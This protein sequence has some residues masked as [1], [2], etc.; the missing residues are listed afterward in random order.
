MSPL[1]LLACVLLPAWPSTAVRVVHVNTL[2]TTGVPVVLVGAQESKRVLGLLRRAGWHPP[3]HSRLILDRRSNSTLR[4]SARAFQLSDEGALELEDMLAEPA[5]ATDL[6]PSR[7][8]LLQLLDQKAIHFEPQFQL[9][10]Y[11]LNENAASVGI[12]SECE[13][14][15]IRYLGAQFQSDTE[16][17][18]CSRPPARSFSFVEL[19]SGIGGFR[20]AL[21]SLRVQADGTLSAADHVGA[22]K[23]ASEI[24]ADARAIYS[25]NFG[26][27]VLS[28]RGVHELT[29]EELPE[30]DLLTAGFPCQSFTEPFGVKSARLP[31]GFRCP[32]GQ[33]FWHIVRLLRS[34]PPSE[35][36]R[37]LLLE[38]VRGLANHDVTQPRARRA[39]RV[40]VDRGGRRRWC[41]SRRQQCKEWDDQRR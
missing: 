38:N 9:H 8:T 31:R 25:C 15:F 41:Y 40:G 6:T 39:G 37:A 22:C 19:F 7:E 27:D 11:I 4:T 21:E 12:S 13:Q 23:F 20:V 33:L 34:K 1:V 17:H 32:R 30:H 36:P 16:R 26:D 29:A 2:R 5:S 28:A 35:R 24:S 14:Q 3:R 18:A 10:E